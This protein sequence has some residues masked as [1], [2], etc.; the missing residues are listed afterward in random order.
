MSVVNLLGTS[1]FTSCPW[2]LS[3]T[4]NCDYKFEAIVSENVCSS[5]CIFHA[6]ITKILRFFLLASGARK[7]LDHSSSHPSTNY[8]I[9][10]TATTTTTTTTSSVVLP[11]KL[12]DP[13]LLKKFPAFYETRKFITTYSR[14]RHLSLY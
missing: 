9:T 8:T 12:T 11:E 2:S 13:K 7:W 1:I 5:S 10:T 4:L 6:K 3:V 14:A